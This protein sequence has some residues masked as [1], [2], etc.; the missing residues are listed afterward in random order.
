MENIIT[1][2]VILSKN[3][4]GSGARRVNIVGDTCANP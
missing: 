2:L 4:M 3:A 1:Q